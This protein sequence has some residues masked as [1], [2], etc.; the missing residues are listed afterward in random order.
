MLFQVFDQCSKI[1]IQHTF[2][3]P[4]LEAPVTCLV[5]RI[6]FWQVAPGSTGTQYPQDAIE[7][8]SGI[9]PR[10]TKTVSP[11]KRIGD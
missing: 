3:V 5:R 10:S 4:P 9:S 1:L 2:L 8:T 6:A 7:D 11:A